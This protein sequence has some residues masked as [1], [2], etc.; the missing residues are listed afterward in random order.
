MG[1]LDELKKLT[2]P[3]DDE[4]FLE[5]EL[6]EPARAPARGGPP[7]LRRLRGASPAAGGRAPAPQSLRRLRH[8]G[9]CAQQPQ[10]QAMAGIPPRAATAPRMP[11]PPRAA[12][13][14]GRV[15]SPGRLRR[16]GALR[17]GR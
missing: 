16:P 17:P 15:S 13:M 1:L 12:A 4:E 2:K 14:P 6:A 10:Q 3:Y 7:G 8:Q 5:D 11:T 9:R